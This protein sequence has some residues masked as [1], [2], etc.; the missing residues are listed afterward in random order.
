MKTIEI[1]FEGILIKEISI[2]KSSKCS[3]IYWNESE[4][5]LM[6]DEKSRGNIPSN[7]LVIF[8]D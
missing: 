3:L 5:T 4:K 6:I 8:N 2:P 7:Y 1:Y